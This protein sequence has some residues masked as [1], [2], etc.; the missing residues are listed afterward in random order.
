MK[1]IEIY[2]LYNIIYSTEFIYKCT[3]RQYISILHNRFIPAFK[4]KLSACAFILLTQL[5]IYIIYYIYYIIYNIYYIYY[6]LYT[7]PNI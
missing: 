1:Y 4:E 6:T 3:I 2:W 7:H 5:V